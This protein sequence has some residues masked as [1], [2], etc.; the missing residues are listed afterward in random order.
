M[1]KLNFE[2]KGNLPRDV[3]NA[4]MPNQQILKS[5]QFQTNEGE[6]NSNNN[7][8]SIGV[9]IPK[10]VKE[11]ALNKWQMVLYSFHKRVFSQYLTQLFLNAQEMER[12]YPYSQFPYVREPDFVKVKVTYNQD[13]SLHHV[14]R[15]KQ[16]SSRLLNE[17]FQ[18]TIGEMNFIP[19]PP[20]LIIN[21]E[22]QFELIFE[23][24]VVY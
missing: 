8:A 22:G 24:R 1:E 12:L 2:W 17:F 16:S 11:E 19:N 15:M 21:P 6:L 18:N 9:V 13:G 4:Q 10:G 23:V 20:K 5:T 14:E 7:N 3:I